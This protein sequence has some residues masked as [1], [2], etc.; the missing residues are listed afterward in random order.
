MNVSTDLRLLDCTHNQLE[1]IPPVL[2]QMASLEQL[3]LRHNKLRFLPELPSS[4]LKVRILMI[5]FP[6][7]MNF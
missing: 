3:Y 1:S 2:S 5:R 7:R 4:R 6:L